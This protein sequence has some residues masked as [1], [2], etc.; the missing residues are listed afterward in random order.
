ESLENA[1]NPTYDDTELRGRIESLEN[2]ENPTYDDTELRGR[3]E[4]LEN[5]ENKSYDDTELRERIEVLENQENTTLEMSAEFLSPIIQN[6]SNF[7]FLSNELLK[8]GVIHA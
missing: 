7:L 5:Q 8:A 2:A 4:S 6:T 1:E 3:I